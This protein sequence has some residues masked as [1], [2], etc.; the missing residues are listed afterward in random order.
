MN[1]KKQG[2]GDFVFISN[3]H[4]YDFMRRRSDKLIALGNEEK[5]II[6]QLE[7]TEQA[8]RDLEL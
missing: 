7:R 6:D 5:R 1:T 4:I 8:N 3:K 2:H